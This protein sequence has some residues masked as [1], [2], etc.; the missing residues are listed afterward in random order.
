VKKLAPTAIAPR[1]PL[2]TLRYAKNG[3]I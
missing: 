3:V 1:R 2:L